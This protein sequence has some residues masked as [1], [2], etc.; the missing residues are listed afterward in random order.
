MLWQ[1][2]DYEMAASSDSVHLI[3]SVAQTAIDSIN[4]LVC[5]VEQ[6]GAPNPEAAQSR[7]SSI[8]PETSADSTTAIRS[9]N[10]LD[11]LRRRFPTR[12]RRGGPFRVRDQRTGRYERSSASFPYTSTSVRRSVGRPLASDI[13]SKDVIIVEIGREKIPTGSEKPQL[14]SS[15]RIVTGFDINRKWDSETLHN[16]LSK[17][18]IGRMEGMHFEIVKNCSGTLLRPNLPRGKEIDS[19][20]LLKSIAPSGCLYLRLL[21]ELPSMLDPTDRQF[22][23]SVFAS[24]KE[25]SAAIQPSD[26]PIAREKIV[27]D[28]THPTPF[29]ASCVNNSPYSTDENEGSSFNETNKHPFDINAIIS[30]AKAQGLTDPAEVLKFLQKMILTG[31]ALE[32]ESSDE[33]IDGET[34]YITVDRERILETTFSELQYITNFRVT[35]QVDFMGEECV[36]NG[37]P[38]REWIRLMNQAIKEK[39]FDHGLRQLLA[40]DYFY[41]GIMIAVALLQN[42]QLPV[43]VEESILQQ[44]VSSQQRSDPCVYQVQRGLEELGLHSALQQLPM[45]VHVLRPQALHKMNVPFLLQIFKPKF[46][47]EGSNALKYEKEVYQLFVKYV[48]EVAASRRVCGETTLDLSHILQFATASAEEPVLGFKL[49]PSLEFV[50]PREV[51]EVTSQPGASEEQQPLIKHDFLPSAHTCT[52]VLQLPRPTDYIAMP[53]MERLYTLYDLAFSQPFFGKK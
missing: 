14:E 16:E 23:V 48:R 21:E 8:E 42:G 31:R 53:P 29:S 41:V 36:D 10:A 12:S 20:L 28:L 24:D 46:S 35:F 52:N 1:T 3:Q 15:G 26:V 37:G 2:I 47:E 13:V 43:F 6:R 4:K 39:Y 7:R 33:T 9:V 19:K 18:L 45:L 17:L 5:L 44:V 27:I 38:R 34:N 25:K 40:Q 22:E 32:V 11:E 49:A 30:E 51:N 50:H